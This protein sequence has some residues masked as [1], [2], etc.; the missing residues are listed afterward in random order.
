[1]RHLTQ[2]QK[3]TA[4]ATAALNQAHASADRQAYAEAAQ[5]EEAAKLLPDLYHCIDWGKEFDGAGRLTVAYIH[6]Y[7]MDDKHEGKTDHERHERGEEH[8][9]TWCPDC[10]QKVPDHT[11]HWITEG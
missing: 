2:R 11:G 7:E 6:M 10:K 3:A 9:L 4:E 1:M 8:Y 5:A